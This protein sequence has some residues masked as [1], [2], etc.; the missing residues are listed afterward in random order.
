MYA[1]ALLA[2]VCLYAYTCGVGLGGRFKLAFTI[3]QRAE[4]EGHP[5]ELGSS[6]EL[7]SAAEFG[8]LVEF[9]LLSSWGLLSS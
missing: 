4:F 6:L 9:G 8:P 7:R 3:L 1:Y 5:L 2:P